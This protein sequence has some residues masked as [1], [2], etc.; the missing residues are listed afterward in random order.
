MTIFIIYKVTNKINGKIYIGFDSNWPHRKN[1][2]K[3]ESNIKNKEQ[4]NSKFH[5][6]I[7][8][9]KSTSF[10]WEIICQSLDGDYLLNEMEPYFIQYYNTFQN[11]YNMTLGGDGCLGREWSKKS[12]TKASNSKIGSKNHFFGKK[13]KK[14]TKEKMSL[15]RKGIK[16]SKETI[17]KRIL[18]NETPAICP[19]CHK[20]GTQQIKRW[21]FNNCKYKLL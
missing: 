11:G 8:K 1:V 2:H 7:R 6:A 12:K 16:Q 14:D 9:Y 20:K 5:R 15:S 13:H 19:Y 10:E 21:H 17:N 4:Y 3:R 18:A